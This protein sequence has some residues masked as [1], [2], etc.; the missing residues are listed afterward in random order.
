[1]N[2]CCSCALK[3]VSQS[4]SKETLLIN[5]SGKVFA[6][7]AFMVWLS[8]ES[9]KNT[10]FHYNV[11]LK[12]KNMN[13]APRN[14]STLVK[15]NFPFFTTYL[16]TKL[17]FSFDYRVLS[18][19]VSS[20]KSYYKKYLYHLGK[21]FCQNYHLDSTNKSP[22][23]QRESGELDTICMSNAFCQVGMVKGGQTSTG[24]ITHQ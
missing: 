20:R 9:T 15:G 7:E 14:R 17:G 11:M 22:S 24:P 21:N 10:L 1:M 23:R 16:H 12:V 8:L 5:N 2:L 4:F 19:A 18:K 13:H 3:K 6:T